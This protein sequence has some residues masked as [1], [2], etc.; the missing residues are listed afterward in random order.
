VAIGGYF[1]LELPV[2]REYHE[3][4]IRLNT[5][6]NALEYI[7]KANAI[8]KLYIPYFTCDVLLE[9]LEKLHI[10]YSFYHIDKNMFPLFTEEIK[11]NEALLY[12]NYFGVFTSQVEE[13][14]QKCARVI[15]DNAQAFFTK[16]FPNIDCFYSARKFFGVPD[17]AYLYCNHSIKEE[18]AQDESY[19]RY[20]YLVGRMEKGA[21]NY[22]AEYKKI[23]SSLSKQAIKQMSFSTQRLLQ[24]IDYQNIISKR[25]SNFSFLHQTLGDTNMFPLHALHTD[26][27]PMVYP[28]TIPQ[29]SELKKYLIANSIYVATYWPNVL[30]WCTEDSWEYFLANHTVF[31]PI[32]QRY[33]TEDMEKIVQ[34]IESK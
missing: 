22:F 1:E 31:I 23:N 21:E 11:E 34:L 30:A 33:G 18:L 24:S 17:G 19:N 27:V 28:Y 3:T 2:N 5:G 10:S 14:L 6:R 8:Q 20:T 29:G 25:K 16:P 32:D 15:V 7:L 12:T 9:P 13:I 4:A 26:D